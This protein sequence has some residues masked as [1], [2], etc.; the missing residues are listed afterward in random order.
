MS[1]TLVQC[2]TNIVC[3]VGKSTRLHVAIT[4]IFQ[5]DTLVLSR[6]DVTVIC[7]IRS[8]EMSPILKVETHPKIMV[9]H[10]AGVNLVCGKLS[11]HCVYFFFVQ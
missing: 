7:V 11:I 3:P 4:G 6:T 8:V 10:L 9:Y 1:M 5:R 2:R